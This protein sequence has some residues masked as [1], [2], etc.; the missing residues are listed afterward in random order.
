M[1]KRATR[2]NRHKNQTEPK[3]IEVTP[4]KID[5]LIREQV[6]ERKKE[7]LPQKLWEKRVQ[8]FFAL[9]LEPVYERDGLDSFRNAVVELTEGMTEDEKVE[10]SL[11]I[12][13]FLGDVQEDEVCDLKNGVFTWKSYEPEFDDFS[14]DFGL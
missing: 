6:E 7:I 2:R 12:S 14:E 8:L 13:D 11:I 1:G 4:L 9:S 3:I 10:L 5:L